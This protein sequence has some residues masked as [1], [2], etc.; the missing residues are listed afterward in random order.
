MKKVFSADAHD[1]GRFPVDWTMG[2]QLMRMMLA[3]G[4]WIG[5]KGF[6]LMLMMLA[7]GRWI[8]KGVSS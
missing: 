7:A 5:E 3:S 1:A 2:F 4:R 8:G 6:Q